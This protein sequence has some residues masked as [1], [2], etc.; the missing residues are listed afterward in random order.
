MHQNGLNRDRSCSTAAT[1]KQRARNTIV[2][3]QHIARHAGTHPGVKA[4]PEILG[5][6]CA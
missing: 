2:R 3:Q 6:A 4:T 1:Y 5:P